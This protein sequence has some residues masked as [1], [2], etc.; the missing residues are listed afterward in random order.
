V[1]KL[2]E[3]LA[4]MASRGRRGGLGG[5]RIDGGGGRDHIVH[6]LVA[7]TPAER[8]ARII[9]SQAVKKRAVRKYTN[10]G[11]TPPPKLAP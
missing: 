9:R 10:R 4:A 1:H 7:E 6:Q 3:L 2:T 5:G 11:V 8:R